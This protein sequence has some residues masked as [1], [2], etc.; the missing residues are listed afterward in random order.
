M[1]QRPSHSPWHQEIKCH[2]FLS[3]FRLLLHVWNEGMTV[4]GRTFREERYLRVRDY[5][6]LDQRCVTQKSTC[7]D[8]TSTSHWKSTPYYQNKLSTFM[9]PRESTKFESNHISVFIWMW[10]LLALLKIR[11]LQGLIG[12]LSKLNQLFPYC[13]LPPNESQFRSIVYLQ[14]CGTVLGLKKWIHPPHFS[15]IWSAVRK[16]TAN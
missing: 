9:R 10:K 11:K 13:V 8:N 7:F 5:M 6:S 16:C 3:Y 2:N 1:E 4:E 14:K 15:L 12:V